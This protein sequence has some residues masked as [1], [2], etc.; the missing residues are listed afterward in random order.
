MIEKRPVQAKLDHVS[1]IASP[2]PPPPPPPPTTN[3]VHHH[4]QRPPTTT[5]L[6]PIQ[7]LSHTATWFI[8]NT[9]P[10]SNT[11]LSKQPS[12]AAPRRN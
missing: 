12:K 9:K 5:S 8:E 10:H 11:W 6:N 3:R 7:S 1:D 4:H 2:P